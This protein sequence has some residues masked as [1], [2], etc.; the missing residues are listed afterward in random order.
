MYPVHGCSIGSACQAG[1]PATSP[2]FDA[3]AAAYA[4]TAGPTSEDALECLRQAAHCRAEPGQATTA[5]RDRSG[6]HLPYGQPAKGGHPLARRTL[7]PPPSSLP[8]DVGNPREL[9]AAE[10]VGCHELDPA[11]G[12]RVVQ[13]RHSHPELPCRVP[14]GHE[15]GPEEAGDR[16]RAD[17]GEA[18]TA[19]G[20]PRWRNR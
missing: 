13:A 9:R 6:R 8:L 11:S 5:L 2:E 12:N 7:P 20:R 1:R 4:R 14:R 18:C 15:R 19:Q 3:L 17:T 16:R 10:A